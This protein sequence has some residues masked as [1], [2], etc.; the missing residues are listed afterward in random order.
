MGRYDYAAFHEEYNLVPD[1]VRDLKGLMGDS[2]D[3]I[4][5]VPGVGEK[6]A[7]KLLHQYGT[8][9]ELYLHLDD[10]AG[11]KLG[12][13]LRDNKEQAF[14]SKELATIYCEVPL[15]FRKEDL[16]VQP[17]Q[18]EQLIAL[19]KDLE[20]R[21]LLKDFLAQY[22]DCLLYTSPSPRD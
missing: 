9:E 2:S 3:N 10:F 21:S 8:V 15:E 4:P 17:V 16:A 13:K 19:Y 5:G 1:Q 22:P 12:E 11:K 14:M 20:L 6:T 18:R 7:L